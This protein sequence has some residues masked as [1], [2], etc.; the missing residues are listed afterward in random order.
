MEKTENDVTAWKQQYDVY[1]L[2][3]AFPL[4]ENKDTAR[5]STIYGSKA[6]SH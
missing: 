2:K 4:E 5:P 3:K 1:S 6:F